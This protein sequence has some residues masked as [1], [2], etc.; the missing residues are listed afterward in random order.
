MPRR[1]EPLH[2]IF[3]LACG[4]MRVF[5]AVIEITT[6]PVFYPRQDLAL[7]QRRSVLRD[8]H[9]D[10]LKGCRVADAVIKAHILISV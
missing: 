10:R 7:G 9:W 4:A 3:A 2:A 8:E 1:L 6:L 5:A